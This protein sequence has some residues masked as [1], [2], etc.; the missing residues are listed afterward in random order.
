MIAHSWLIFMHKGS[1]RRQKLSLHAAGRAIDIH[2][3]DVFFDLEKS[4]KIKIKEGT[5]DAIYQVTGGD[6]PRELPNF[7]GIFRECWTEAL[8][9]K[10]QCRKWKSR[11][12]RGSVGSED[13]YHTKHIHLSFPFCPKNSNFLGA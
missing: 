7:F 13:P 11:P 8:V 12:H 1:A 3:V 6:L 5:H 10:R 9:Q 4:G 2:S